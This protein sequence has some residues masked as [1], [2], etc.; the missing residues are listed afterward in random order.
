MKLLI[1]L[2]FTKVITLKICSIKVAIKVLS[3]SH[4]LPS[5][6]EFCFSNLFLFIVFA[7][8]RNKVAIVI[9]LTVIITFL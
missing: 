7:D 2:H 8:P 4:T 6:I 1:N 5:V 3:F 9:T